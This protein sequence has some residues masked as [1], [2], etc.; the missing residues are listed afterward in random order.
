LIS[1]APVEDSGRAI[2]RA[3]VTVLFCFLAALCEGFDVQ[4]A[5]VAALGLSRAFTPTP[6]Q[7]GLFFS[8]GNVGLLLGAIAGG[9]AADY[10]GRKTVLVCSIA[11]F[12][13]FSVATSLASSME[14]F[15]WMKTE[16]TDKTRNVVVTATQKSQAMIPLLEQT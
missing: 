12:G 14:S 5:G 8:S 7:L 2:T 3:R 6:E 4:A 16:P 9:R 1:A 15:T 11:L 13:V 10:L